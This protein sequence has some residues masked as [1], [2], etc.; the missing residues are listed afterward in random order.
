MAKQKTNKV[1]IEV[2]MNMETNQVEVKGPLHAKPMVCS[3]L[4]QAIVAVIRHDVPVIRPAGDAGLRE[5]A[6]PPEITLP[7]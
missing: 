4:A 2:S 6:T 1:T 5:I 3:I 7:N